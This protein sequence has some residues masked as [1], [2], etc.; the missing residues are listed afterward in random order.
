MQE[1]SPR[2]NPLRRRNYPYYP[3]KSMDRL[4][5]STA[6][7]KSSKKI[8]KDREPIADFFPNYLTEA[9]LLIVR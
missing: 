4:D 6:P 5:I 2:R 9:E 3:R 8:I 7:P 1:S